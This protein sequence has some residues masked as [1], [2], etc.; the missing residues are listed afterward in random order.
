MIA[1]LAKIV[2]NNEVSKSFKWQ[3]YNVLRPLMAFFF[4]SFEWNQA[5]LQVPGAHTG[6][7][8][9]CN[10]GGMWCIMHSMMFEAQMTDILEHVSKKNKDKG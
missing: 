7:L 8:L 3:I 9:R 5:D 4:S 10:E 6:V 1:S 2:Q